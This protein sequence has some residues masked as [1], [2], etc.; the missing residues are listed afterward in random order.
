MGRLHHAAAD[1]QWRTDDPIGAGPF[2]RERGPDDVDDRIE[3]PDLVKVDLFHRHLVDGGFRLGQPRE[4][5]RCALPR[6]CGER[7]LADEGENLRQAAVAMMVLGARRWLLGA[8]RRTMFV[9]RGCL[10]MALV[11]DELRGGH[12]G[13]EDT[14]GA[15]VDVSERQAAKR[16]CQL[17][18]GHAGIEKRAKRHVAGHAGEAIEIQDTRH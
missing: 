9:V 3:R 14:R 10:A 6:S 18:E 1:V 5:A 15:D 13:A 12:T 2:K 11:H 16:A 17:V 7:R 8:V 4:H